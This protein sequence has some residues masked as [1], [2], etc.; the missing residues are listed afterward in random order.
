[1]ISS[2]LLLITT[3]LKREVYVIDVY[4]N[5]IQYLVC[6]FMVS[7]MGWVK[8]VERRLS[9]RLI[10]GM[11]A[12]VVL[13]TLMSIPLAVALSAIYLALALVYCNR[14]LHDADIFDI[15]EQSLLK[16]VRRNKAFFKPSLMV[17]ATLAYW[18]LLA[19]MRNHHLLRISPSFW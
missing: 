14:P 5:A 15:D 8:Q 17:T 1:M 7:Y 18:V 9:L 12:H 19:Y 11:A 13:S 2:L 6:I 3:S 4:L 10:V 16:L